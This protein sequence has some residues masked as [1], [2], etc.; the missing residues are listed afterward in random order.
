MVSWPVLASWL[1]LQCRQASQAAVF[2]PNSI[3]QLSQMYFSTV[4]CSAAL[5]NGRHGSHCSS[6]L[7]AAMPVVDWP[8]SEV[9]SKLHKWKSQA[10]VQQPW[11]N[12]KVSVKL[13]LIF[14]QKM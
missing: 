14:I 5:E 6:L 13:C 4:Q 1:G 9:F 12:I 11:E 3:S 7:G 2:L 8:T 10:P